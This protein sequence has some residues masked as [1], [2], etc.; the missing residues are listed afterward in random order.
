MKWTD[1]FKQAGRGLTKAVSRYPLTLLFLLAAAIVNAMAIEDSTFL[2]SNHNKLFAAFIVGAFLATLAQILYEMREGS[3]GKRLALSGIAVALTAGY[4]AIIWNASEFG[5]EIVV[6]TAAILSAIIMGIIF[7]P[8]I[9]GKVAFHKT[10]M[11]AFKGFF[12]SVF[13]SGVLFVGIALIIGAIDLLL[14][15]VDEKAF[16]HSANIIFSLFA[17]T[18]FLSL[19][20]N[21]R[22]ADEELVERTVGCPRFLEIL[23]SNILIPLVSVFTVILVVYIGMNV[24]GEFWSE[25]LTEPML[26]SYSIVVI[27]LL[28]LS[29]SLTNRFTTLFKKIFP[30]VLLPLVVLQLIA[31]TLK[32]GDMGLTHSRYYVIMYGV[33]AAVAGLVFSFLKPNKIN[34][35]AMVFIAFSLLSTVPPVDAFGVSKRNQ[36]GTLQEVLERNEMLVDGKIVP[37][38]NISDEDKDMIINTAQYIWRMDYAQDVEWLGKGFDYYGNFERTFG[39]KWD[40]FYN[41]GKEFRVFNRNRLQGIDISGYDALAFLRYYSFDPENNLTEKTDVIYNGK[42]YQLVWMV[43]QPREH[44]LVLKDE[45]GTE[46]VSLPMDDLKN[47]FEGMSV[48]LGMQKGLTNEQATFEAQGSGARLKIVVDS[49]EMVPAEQNSDEWNINSEMNVLVDLTIE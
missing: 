31:S 19:M 5:M 11:G 45:A 46:L 10:F 15:S 16:M 38:S 34:I 37:K 32:I 1:R 29:A 49:Y 14:F 9:K 8:S 22:T 12:I 18:Y 47:R 28:I 4:L 27:I 17:P 6:R 3:L 24:T 25:N 33:F 43:D 35:I 36:I 2:Q 30:K 7:V 20:P 26:V 44:R 41:D 13:F 42:T 39:F 40:E 21:Y 48:E 23:I